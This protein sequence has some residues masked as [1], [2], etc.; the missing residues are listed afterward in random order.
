MRKLLS[1][2]L[3]VV[4]MLSLVGASLSPGLVKPHGPKVPPI[5]YLM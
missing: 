2:S 5:E 4:L 3:V 1:K